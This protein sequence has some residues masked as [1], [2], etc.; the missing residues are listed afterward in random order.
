MDSVSI[1][2]KYN[3]H[4]YTLLYLHFQE[5]KLQVFSYYLTESIIKLCQ[6]LIFD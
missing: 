3:I 2:T 5:P 4:T 1:L 6:R